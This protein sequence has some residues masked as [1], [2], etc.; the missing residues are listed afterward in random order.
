MGE[1]SRVTKQEAP[2]LQITVARLIVATAFLGAGAGCL[3]AAFSVQQSWPD[4]RR[5]LAFLQFLT[6]GPLIGAG[7]MAPFHQTR[8]G[9][10]VGF[11]AGIIGGIAGAIV[12]AGWRHAPE[13][14]WDLL[15]VIGCTLMAL[16]LGVLSIA[17]K[18]KSR[19]TRRVRDFTI[20]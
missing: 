1:S 12:W 16:A 2:R 20:L 11:F 5:L 8:V 18:I 17:W 13:I 10:Y 15:Y 19:P 3:L 7:L 14:L 4:W 6:A 9:A